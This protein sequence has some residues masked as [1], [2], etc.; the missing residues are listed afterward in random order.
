MPTPAQL[1]RSLH[2]L[3]EPLH[4]ILYF[5]PEAVAEYEA[6]GLEGRA[7]CYVAGRSAPLGPVGPAVVTAVFFNFNPALVETAVPAAWEAAAPEDVLAARFR[8]VEAVYERVDAPRGDLAEATDL[9]RQAAASAGVAG[10][11]L[12][13]ANAAVPAPG[14][15]FADLWQ[16][17]TVLREHRGDGHVAVLTVEDVG[18][19]EALAMY[20]AWQDLVSRRFLQRSRLWD[21]DA[22]TAAEQRLRDR[23]WYGADG[24]L[25]EAGRG[26]RDSIERR[27]DELAAGPYRALDRDDSLRLFDLLRP[28]AA[29]L[30]DAAAFPR[31]VILPERPD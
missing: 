28:L 25:S 10:R 18:P 31:Q 20:A 12:A 16:A 13:S 4:S 26:W 17:L 21:D 1:A 27:T 5:A 23:D 3:I 2:G 19:V 30:N 14:M 9:A 6:L 7:Q 24:E 22:W 8:A 11:A 29:A 15:P